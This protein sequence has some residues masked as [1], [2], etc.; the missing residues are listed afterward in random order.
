MSVA[1]LALSTPLAAQSSRGGRAG[2]MLGFAGTLGSGWQVEAV[3]VGYVRVVRAGP[4]RVATLATRLGSFMDEGAIVGGSR[5]FVFGLTV[6]GHTG[7]RRIANLGTETSSSEIG[8]D[9]SV[10]A[11]AYLGARTPLA[12]G[13]PWGAVTILPGLRFGD[14]DG[15]Q[16]GLLIGPT[17]FFGDRG[18]VRPFLGLRYEAPLAR[19]EPRP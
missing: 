2:W 17:F 12:V 13:S 10:E 18:D 15:A 19:R 3:D 4:L 7:L 14:P 9:L 1:L 16:F 11:T 8:V 6:G 5:G